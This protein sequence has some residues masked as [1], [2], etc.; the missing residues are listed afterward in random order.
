MKNIR[1][2]LS[3]IL[4]LSASIILLSTSYSKE[5]GILLNNEITKEEIDNILI[6]YSKSNIIS[7][8][9]SNYINITNKNNHPI[10][11]QIE[12][13]KKDT[14]TEEIYYE[15]DNNDI[16]ILK[17]NSIIIEEE[18][19]AYGTDKDTITH[20][21]NI[22]S[23]KNNKYV[24][25]ITE[26]THLA[27]VIKKDQVYENNNNYYYYGD[28]PNNYILI[29]NKTYRILGI[30]NNKIKLISNNNELKKYE[31]DNNYPTINDILNSIKEEVNK[32]NI[33][34]YKTYLTDESYWL[35]DEYNPYMNYYFSSK[36]EIK[37]SYK[38]ILHFTREIKY[39]DGNIKVEKGS[40]TKK[41]PYEVLYES[42]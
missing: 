24:I 17:K 10:T 40:G 29:N 13:L 21:I 34:E 9:E 1:Y 27:N 5:S 8:N 28:E 30:E 6:T 4:I 39:L 19:S 12:L 2:Y 37:T 11:Y 23:N 31:E 3:L 14:N 36:N 15:L 35:K 38:N 16:K 22:Q 42:N 25:K 18:L 41:E 32:Y 26:T 33:N 7:P 20:R